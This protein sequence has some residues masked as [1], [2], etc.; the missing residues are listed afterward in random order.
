MLHRLVLEWQSGPEGTFWKGREL[1]EE[2]G[3]GDWVDGHHEEGH[4]KN[5]EPEVNGHQGPRVLQNQRDC[6]DDGRQEDQSQCH[7]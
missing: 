4:H 6:C 7:L 1:V 2:W 3:N 5:E